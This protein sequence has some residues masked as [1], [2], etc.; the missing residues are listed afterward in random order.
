MTEIGLHW[1]EQYKQEATKLSW[2]D[3]KWKRKGKYNQILWRETTEKG[4]QQVELH[5]QGS[6]NAIKSTTYAIF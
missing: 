3:K 1:L 2:V 6:Q 5:K 4:L